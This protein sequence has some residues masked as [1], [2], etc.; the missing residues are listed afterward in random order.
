MKLVFVLFFIV[1]LHQYTQGIYVYSLEEIFG[2]FGRLTEDESKLKTIIDCLCSFFKD[3]YAYEEVVKNP[4]QPKFDPNYHQ[5]I[6]IVEGLKNIE[7]KD[8]DMY[9]FY[10]AI[11]L[12]FDSLGDQHLNIDI[13]DFL[14]KEVH[15]TD[16]LLLKVKKY[17]DEVRMFAEVKVDEENYTHF[18]NYE[19]VFNAIRENLNI[20]I[21]TINGKDPFDFITYFGGNYE[22]LKSPQGSFRYKLFD[23]N[24]EQDIFDF[25][26]S[27]KDFSNF[28][29]VYDSGD[30]FVTDYMIYSEK[31]LREEDFKENIKSFINKFKNINES[32]DNL[33]KNLL[34]QDILV[35]RNDKIYR[36]LFK[37][38]N[39]YNEKR[40]TNSINAGNQWDYT[41]SNF[42]A[43]RVDKDKK[44]NI[45]GIASFG[46]EYDNR[47]PET[48]K[49]CVKLID[50]NDYPV[51]LV[52][53]MN[54]GGLVT[55]AQYLLEF[56]SP[57]T[58][59]NFY[60]AIRKSSIFEEHTSTL[61][62]LINIFSD[63]ED[64]DRY[65]YRAFMKTEKKV[66]YGNS[67]SDNLLGPFFFNGRD[68]RVEVNK[69]KQQLKNPRKPTDILI[70]TDGFSYSATSLLLK[71]I[72]Y[73]G[74]A[75]TAGYFTNPNLNDI[76][77]DSSLSPSS[78]LGPEALDLLQPKGYKTLSTQFKYKIILPVT[79]TFYSP[80]DLTRPLEYEVTPVDETVN[81][82]INKQ[83]D[84]NNILDIDNYDIFIDDSLKIF[85]KYKTQCNP[86]NK[87]L[88]LITNKCD[89][90]LGEFTHGGYIC[91]EDGFWTQ[92]CVASYCDIGYFFDHD[93][94]KC[95]E[96]PCKEEN[97]LLK[98]I[99]V[100]LIIIIVI[101][102]IV[103]VFYICNKKL[104]Q[105]KLLRQQ[106]YLQYLNSKNN[107]NNNN[108]DN[109]DNNNNNDN[110]D[111]NL[112]ITE[113]LMNE[114]QTLNKEKI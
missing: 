28:T 53:I 34:I 95:V 31:K 17:N 10:G 113:S 94:K 55:N 61:D 47:Y 42:F 44:I 30:S 39:L 49:K 60:A 75:I 69:F 58:E 97:V 2:I 24:S 43:C 56:L 11:K 88:L 57:K 41:Y 63:I 40:K 37:T 16:P 21:K 96:N 36:K 67:V 59:L 98:F 9:K 52:N 89:G 3:I 86:N 81:I 54:G 78:I 84:K 107:N 6:N 87:K 5:K 79:H 25:P 99:I 77:Y 7:I 103:V 20:P 80:K 29:V 8:T 102:A 45:F 106:Q 85:E 108:N 74:G 100:I 111:N 26:L 1:I 83:I 48:I 114:E 71:Y 109:N 35:A 4:P 104:K 112:G 22:K 46:S 105:R 23:H 76:P 66:N 82:F 64:C 15:F 68:F 91:G 72:Q 50:N 32:N 51:I 93:E 65:G 18:R 70:Y 73:Y 92:K 33:N 27:M 62:Q 12:L 38:G 110:N 19:E 101:T 90:K 13:G 14:L